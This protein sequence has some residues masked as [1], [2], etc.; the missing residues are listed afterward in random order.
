MTSCGEFAPLDNWC[1]L[2]S[3]KSESELMEPRQGATGDPAVISSSPT[4]PSFCVVLPVY[5]E[6]NGIEACIA[7]IA[8]FLAGVETQTGIV[9]VDDGSRDDSFA[10]LTRLRAR[11]PTLV[12]CQHE[13]NR[14]YG[15]ANRTACRL[16]IELGFDYALVMDADGTQRPDYIERFFEP[17]RRGVDLVKATRYAQGGGIEGV[18]WQRY[19]ISL[20]GNKLAHALMRVPLTDF[21]NGFRA[22][23]AKKWPLL[24]TMEDG[25]AVLIEEV[26]LARRLGFSFAEV[27][28]ILRIRQEPGSVSK[29]SYAWRI[30]WSYLKYVLAR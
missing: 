25:F 11:Y 17:M 10:I 7:G 2:D 18:P 5:N 15:V 27:P 28:Y 19:V 26:Y 6:A 9:A 29:F 1:P 14:G 12:V 23:R 8:E 13:Q 22:V 4:L 24:A 16:V 20:V 3:T 30:Y 21:S